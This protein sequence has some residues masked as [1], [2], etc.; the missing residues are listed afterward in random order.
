MKRYFDDLQADIWNP[1][2]YYDMLGRLL[3]VYAKLNPG[4]GSAQGFATHGQRAGPT[5]RLPDEWVT[6]LGTVM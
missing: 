6:T 1:R 4:I 5:V 2:T 3:F